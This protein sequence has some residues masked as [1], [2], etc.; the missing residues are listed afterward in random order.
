[1]NGALEYR[2]GVRGENGTY[3]LLLLCFE[4]ADPLSEICD[5]DRQLH[6]HLAN[7]R[8]NDSGHLRELFLGRLVMP[9]MHRVVQTALYMFLV[10][11]PKLRATRARVVAAGSARSRG[12]A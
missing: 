2:G 3:R 12:C 1:M 8:E 6:C 10:H 4:G 9:A 5:K 7:N 11:D